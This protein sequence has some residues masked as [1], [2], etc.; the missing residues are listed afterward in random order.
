MTKIHI[1]VLE[2]G[3]I[4]PLNFAEYN[5]KSIEGWNVNYRTLYSKG[6]PTAKPFNHIIFSSVMI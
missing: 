5:F 1:Y 4:F 2:A 3:M 6:I